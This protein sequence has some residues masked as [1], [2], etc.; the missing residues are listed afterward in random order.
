MSELRNNF[1]W[2]RHSCGSFFIF[3]LLYTDYLYITSQLTNSMGLG[4]LPSPKN[5]LQEI[6]VKSVF[7]KTLCLFIIKI[8]YKHHYLS[9]HHHHHHLHIHHRH[10]Q[11]HHHQIHI[12]HH[13]CHHQYHNHDHHD[14]HRHHHHQ[15]LGIKFP[16]EKNISI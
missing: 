10:H 4:N 13:H 14:Q 16:R 1:C 15:Q 9:C 2:I 7:I 3:E 5:H 12:H 6:L 8:L 11:Y